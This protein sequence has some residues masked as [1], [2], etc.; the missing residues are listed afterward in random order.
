MNDTKTTFNNAPTFTAEEV[1][2]AMKPYLRM[3]TLVS[4]ETGYIQFKCWSNARRQFTHIISVG[5]K[6]EGLF[7]Y[8]QTTC[9]ARYVTSMEELRNV[10]ESVERGADQLDEFRRL[11]ELD[12]R[13]GGEDSMRFDAVL[14]PTFTPEAPDIH[15]FL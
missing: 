9:A 4:D 10:L 14:K 11:L 1:A 15:P 8:L 5:N 7:V 13:T 6:E 12:K 3:L 2:A